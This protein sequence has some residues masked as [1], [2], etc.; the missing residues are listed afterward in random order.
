MVIISCRYVYVITNLY[1][2][3]VVLGLHANE[4]HLCGGMEALEAVKALI[5]TTGDEFELRTYERL[6]PLK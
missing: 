4:I 5:S 1:R 3:R 6:S 2:T